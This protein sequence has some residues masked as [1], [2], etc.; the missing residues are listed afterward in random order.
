MLFVPGG[1]YY[2]NFHPTVTM[3]QNMLPFEYME[4]MRYGFSLNLL[5][6]YILRWTQLL[7]FK[8]VDGLIYLS[9]YAFN[10]IN[11]MNKN[12]I[13]PTKIVSHG[14]DDRFRIMPKKQKKIH[15][16][17]EENPY[18]L[19]YVSSLEPYKH[20]WH[21]VEAISIIRKLGYKVRVYFIGPPNS[22]SSLNRLNNAINLFDPN[23]QFSF[24]LGNIPFDELHNKYKLADLSIFASTCENMPN[25]LLESMAAGLP[26]ACSNRSV[27]PEILLDGGLYFDPTNPK[28]IANCIIK[29]IES[30]KLRSDL[31]IINFNRSQYYSWELC[32]KETFEFIENVNRSINYRKK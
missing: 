4:L 21:V 10:V 3:C 16:Y 32:V 26:I 25:I 12:I 13:C 20:Q 28:D 23:K 18:N 22:K 24:Y 29:L 19:I 30:P 1:S 27:M 31:S 8:K 15:L 14:I 9:Q 7:S 17:T 5:R 11:N 2:G 6:L